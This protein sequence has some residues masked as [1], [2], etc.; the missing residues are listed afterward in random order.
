MVGDKAGS[1]T[2]WLHNNLYLTNP[3]THS[4]RLFLDD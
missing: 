2:L 1:V 4:L 3:D